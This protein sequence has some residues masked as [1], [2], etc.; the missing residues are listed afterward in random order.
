MDFT[1]KGP[2]SP[3]HSIKEGSPE[4][5]D[6]KP[7]IKW[8]HWPFGINVSHE[9]QHNKSKNGPEDGHPDSC[10]ETGFGGGPIAGR[11]CPW[12]IITQKH[13]MAE[14]NEHDECGRDDLQ[15]NKLRR[16]AVYKYDNP[17]N[18]KN[19]ELN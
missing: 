1:L 8:A 12:P 14:G 10:N 17:D 7:E 16:D 13:Q 15:Y 4:S 19:D 2:S 3:V 6:S 18:S 11:R 5:N 9:E